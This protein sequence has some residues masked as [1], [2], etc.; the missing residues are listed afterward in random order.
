MSF[1][2]ENPWKH[3]ENR[4]NI[5]TLK[6]ISKDPEQLERVITCDESEFTTIEDSSDVQIE[7]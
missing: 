7:S 3:R 2:F 1:N 6:N 4:Y 5:E